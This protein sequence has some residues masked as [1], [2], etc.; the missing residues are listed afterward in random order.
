MKETSGMIAMLDFPTKQRQGPP[1]AEEGHRIAN[2][3]SH[4]QLSEIWFTISNVNFERT[5][6]TSFGSMW[7]IEASHCK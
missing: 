4:K 1:G 3:S 5:E 2:D 6:T 7:K